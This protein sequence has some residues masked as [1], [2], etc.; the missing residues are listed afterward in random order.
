MVGKS[1]RQTSAFL[2]FRR[3]YFGYRATAGDGNLRTP[4]SRTLRYE[5]G[6]GIGDTR[7]NV[8]RFTARSVTRVPFSFSFTTRAFRVKSI[9]FARPLRTTVVPRT[10][11]IP[12]R[13]TAYIGDET[14]VGPVPFPI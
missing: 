9:T 14:R 4:P 10:A 3:R 12:Q 13:L 2:R 7:G 1:E 11:Q 8:D 5:T 6:S